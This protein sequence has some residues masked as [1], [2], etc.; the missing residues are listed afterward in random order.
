MDGKEIGVTPFRIRELPIGNYSA[1]LK[2]SGYT[3]RNVEWEIS[4]ARPRMIQTVLQS[5]VGTLSV[6]S[7][8]KAALVYLDEQDVGRTPY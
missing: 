1:T 5:N 6:K 3:R 4:D 7:L 8:P 2:L